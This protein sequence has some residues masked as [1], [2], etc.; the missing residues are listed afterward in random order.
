MLPWAQ[1][2]AS[3]AGDESNW[4]TPFSSYQNSTPLDHSMGPQPNWSLVGAHMP[5][6]SLSASVSAREASIASSQVQPSAGWS[7]PLASNR[8]T[9]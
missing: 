4:D 9:L 1:A 8:E 3:I 6:W 5:N 2:S 7:T